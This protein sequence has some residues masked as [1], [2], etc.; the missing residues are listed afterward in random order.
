M[1]SPLNVD[2]RDPA[3]QR[4][5]GMQ[6][7]LASGKRE[8]VQLAGDAPDPLGLSSARGRMSTTHLTGL[9]REVLVLYRDLVMT[10]DV[11]EVPG[12]P[13]KLHLYCPRCQKHST[14]PGDRKAID[15]DGAASNPACRDILAMGTV[16]PEL[17]AVAAVGR[18]SVATFECAWEL[19]DE[20]HVAGAL[21]TGTTLC[22]LRIAIDNNRAKDA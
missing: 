5:M 20:R 8:V 9:K 1:S 3:V 13:L 4:M 12:E 7:P 10:V 6:S 19:G 15:F 11:Y 14:V 21:S 18:L 22:R 2:F 16:P 17:H